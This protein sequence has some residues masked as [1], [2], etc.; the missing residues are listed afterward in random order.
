LIKSVEVMEKVEFNT[1]DKVKGR[2]GE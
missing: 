1:R 2:H